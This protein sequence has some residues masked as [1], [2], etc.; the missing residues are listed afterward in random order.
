MSGSTAIPPGSHGTPPREPGRAK[1]SPTTSSKTFPSAKRTLTVSQ[2]SGQS[3]PSPSLKERSVAT[4]AQQPAPMLGKTKMLGGKAAPQ[5]LVSQQVG[6]N[7]FKARLAGPNIPG[8][9][10]LG[11]MKL[12]AQAKFVPPPKEMHDQRQ[13]DYGESVQMHEV[14]LRAASQAGRD[15]VRVEGEQ[16]ILD[17]LTTKDKAL[18][19]L[20]NKGQKTPEDEAAILVLQKEIKVLSKQ[21]KI[22]IKGEGDVWGAADKIFSLADTMNNS[23]GWGFYLVQQIGSLA[24]LGVPLLAGAGGY[25]ATSIVAI[26]LNLFFL[27]REYQQH[28]R[29][30]ALEAVAEKKIGLLAARKA[31]G[32]SLGEEEKLLRAMNKGL[33]K[34]HDRT[35]RQVGM[36]TRTALII[37]S[38]AISFAGVTAFAAMIGIAGASGALVATGPIGL[39]VGSGL[40]M[41]AFTVLIIYFSGKNIIAYYDERKQ[42]GLFKETVDIADK[43]DAGGS[44]YDL[45]NNSSGYYKTLF[46]K[47]MEEYGFWESLD[48]KNLTPEKLREEKQR[49][50]E[51]LTPDDFKELNRIIANKAMRKLVRYNS[52]FAAELLQRMLYAESQKLPGSERVFTEWLQSLDVFKDKRT[53]GEIASVDVSSPYISAAAKKKAVKVLAEKVFNA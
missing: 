28:E 27:H 10:W 50:I 38:C 35:G 37:S 34:Q 25:A 15:C 52:D 5:E 36:A 33:V 16:G 2:G 3:S 11:R 47:L 8:G 23:A 46:E 9:K 42:F 30:S 45:Y 12:A 24:S 18:Q 32:E 20:L 13:T 26:P 19:A 49:I 4:P 43:L 7:F 44:G 41:V 51:S 53:L 14:L 31:G 40:A 1:L 22:R 29:S 48:P 39:I 6:R 21:V 17:E